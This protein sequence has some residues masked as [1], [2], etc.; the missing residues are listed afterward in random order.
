VTTHRFVRGWI[1]PV[2]FLIVAGHL[3]VPYLL[4]RRTLSI[5]AVCVVLLIVAKH[6]GVAAMIW[7]GRRRR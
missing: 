6:A 1:V 5:A 7:R 2:A 3:L 4:F